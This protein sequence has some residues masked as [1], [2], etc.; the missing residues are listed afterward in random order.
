MFVCVRMCER[1]CHGRLHHRLTNPIDLLFSII[2]AVNLTNN[3]AQTGNGGGA[4]I[5]R[6]TLD[7]SRGTSH[8]L[9][10]TA[11]YGNGGGLYIADNA[12]IT[13]YRYACGFVGVQF[14]DAKPKARAHHIPSPPLSS[15]SSSRA[16]R[17]GKAAVCTATTPRLSS[18]GRPALSYPTPRRL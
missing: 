11:P 3:I 13:I 4:Y 7:T 2:R 10:N 14:I 12:G 15:V 6:T 8:F 9:G 5:D 16:T 1:S 18:P 17:R